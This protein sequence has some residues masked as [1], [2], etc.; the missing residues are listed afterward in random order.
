MSGKAIIGGVVALV[1]VAGLAFMVIKPVTVF[2]ITGEGLSRSITSELESEPQGP[3]QLECDKRGENVY[4]CQGERFGDTEVASTVEVDD[5]GCWEL[6]SG[7]NGVF[8]GRS[9][10][11]DLRNAT[12]AL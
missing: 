8:K 10:C 1:V 7:F 6:T 2:G 3:A 11:I 5:D 9:G 12:G 4:R